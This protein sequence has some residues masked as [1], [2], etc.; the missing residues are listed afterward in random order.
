MSD[1]TNVLTVLKKLSIDEI[2]EN[3]K[4]EPKKKRKIKLKYQLITQ[5]KKF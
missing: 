3:P 4:P 2:V 1:N 5:C